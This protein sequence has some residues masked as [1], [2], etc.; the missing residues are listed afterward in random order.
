MN[1][2]TV[3]SAEV[4]G[5]GREAHYQF[6]TS[7]PQGRYP[8]VHDFHELVLVTRGGMRYITDKGPL[9][10]MA[11]DLLH[12]C[13]GTVHSKEGIGLCEH[14]NL[15]FPSATVT[16]VFDFLGVPAA[17]RGRFYLEGAHKARLGK[18][19]AA[20][21]AGAMRQLG[22]LHATH[23][24]A[25][26]MNLRIILAQLFAEHFLR[27]LSGE[28][29]DTAPGWLVDLLAAFEDRELL[30][31]SVEDL[32]KAAGCTVEHLCRVFR[33]AFGL[34]PGAYIRQRRMNYA[35][36]LLLHSDL[37]AIDI[38]YEAGYQSLAPFYAA[39]RREFGMAPLQYR[40]ARL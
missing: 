9:V 32:A 30:S 38:A 25:E 4:F 15:A 34:T 28:A 17:E 27:L 7:I 20:R 18:R 23:S 14:I 33:G 31:A 21:L 36:N 35:A 11:G 24:A 26:R 19:Q 39:F 3:N 1:I 8:Q 22:R 6:L 12:A 2:Q 13:P 37:R 40:K 29:Q 16:A 5:I 10:L